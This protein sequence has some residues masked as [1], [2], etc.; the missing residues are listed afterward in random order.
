MARLVFDAVVLAVLLAAV[1]FVAGR[2]SRGKRVPS[3]PTAAAVSDALQL[4]AEAGLFTAEER[5]AMWAAYVTRVRA[6]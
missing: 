1:A 4:L 6:A 2:E 3:D 5:E